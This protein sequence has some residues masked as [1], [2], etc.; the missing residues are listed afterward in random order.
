MKSRNFLALVLATVML[1]SLAACGGASD[2]GKT[3][4]APAEAQATAPA[5]EEAAQPVSVSASELSDIDAQLK[6]IHDN[7][8]KLLQPVGELPWFYAVT[9][10]NHD[11]SLELI[12]ASQH[13]SDRSTNLKLWETSKDHKSLVEC[14]VEK[15]AEESFPDIMTDSMDTFHVKA[16]DSWNYL[17]Y[18]NIV[19]SDMEV[20]TSKSAFKLKDGVISYESFA[21][22]HT[23]VE[24]GVKTTTHTD[25]DGN[26]ISP[27]QYNAS[28]IAAFPDAERRNTSFEWLTA[29][30]AK[31]II[32]LTDSYAVFMGV[33]KATENFP[34]PKPAALQAPEATAAPA[35]TATPAPTSTPAPTPVPTPVP[36]PKYLEIT[37]NP[38]NE[39]KKTGETALFV[40][41]ANVFD[42]LEWTIVSPDGGEY[43]PTQFTN[44]YPGVA[45]YGL[46]STTLGFNNLI[47]QLNGWGAYCT[48]Y[49][50]GQVARTSTAYMFVTETKPEP[51][52]EGHFDGSVY[53]WNYSYVSIWSNQGFSALVDWNNVIL[54]GDIYSGAPATCYWTGNRNNVVACYIQGSEPKPEPKYGSTSGYAHEG[55][56]GYAID[57]ANGT[58]VYVDA[59][60]CSLEGRFYDGCYCNVFYTDYPSSSNIYQVDI[61]GDMGLIVPDQGGWAGSHYYDS[62]PYEEEDQYIPEGG[63]WAG[64]NYYDNEGYNG[65]GTYGYENDNYVNGIGTHTSFNDDGSTYEA[66]WCPDCGTEVSLA[67]E[68]CPGCGRPF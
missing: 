21:V 13:P 55:G 56:G 46:Y 3:Q 24:N 35:A 61:Y 47:K 39:N 2:S 51:Q 26:E 60:K 52:S 5:A 44:M 49:Y 7:I 27:E 30:D 20:Y 9:D 11:G 57:L 68:N 12:A 31:N 15:D 29:E 10:L 42:S 59:W 41:C 18:D 17:F 23:V 66:I 63:G 67:M 65:P 54:D 34:V 40:A 62:M 64:A 6:L 45:V 16:D 37:K 53:D 4:P 19:L 33:K 43:N 48:F 28:G 58:Q 36:Q 8:D 14:S 50:Q 38:T 22:E 1:F 25:N 32:R